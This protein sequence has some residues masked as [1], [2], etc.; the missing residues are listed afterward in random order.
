MSNAS[1]LQQFSCKWL[2]A[3]DLVDFFPLVL[4]IRISFNAYPNPAFSLNADPDPGS[5]TNADPDKRIRILVRL[6]KSRIF[7]LKI[8]LKVGNRSR[9]IPK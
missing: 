4:W 3:F 9:N 8:I 2:P 1:P 5:Q 7:T 6:I